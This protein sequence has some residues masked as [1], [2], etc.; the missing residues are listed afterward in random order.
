MD[1]EKLKQKILDLAIRGKLVPQDSN[2]ESAEELIKKIQEE[3]AKLVKEG[4]IKAS[5][6]ESIIFKGSDNCYYE[7]IGNEIKNISDEI[8][9]EIPENWSWIRLNELGLYRKGPFGSSLTKSMFVSEQTIGRIKV[10]EQRN[11]IQKNAHIG[12]YF[13]SKEKFD[14][15]QGFIVEPGDIIVSCAGT[16]GEIYILP[17]NSEIGIIN[18]AL[19]RIRLYYKGIEEYFVLY[20]DSILKKEANEKGMGSTIK[21]IPP[22]DIL[23]KMLLPLPPLNE[24]QRILEKISFIINEINEINTNYDDI[25]KL[26]I[27]IKSKILDNFFGEDSSY[28]SYYKP[29]ISTNLSEL[30]PNDNIGDGDWVLTENMDEN[31]NYSLIQLKHVGYGQYIEKPY[32]HVNQSFFETNNCKEIKEDYILI[33]RLIAD[34]MNVCILPQKGFKCIIAVDICWIAPSQTYN[35]KYIMYYLM[36]PTFQ[37]K[38][39]MITSGTTR[40]RISKTNLIKIPML[41]HEHNYQSK[42]VEEIENAFKILDSI[43]S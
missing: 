34:K 23:K 20:F 2:N 11:A 8:P 32:K 14:T 9:F 10:Y 5:K 30:I 7:K 3:K 27:K 12:N 21:N 39:K 40:K 22:F 43:V 15:M 16:I 4:K 6:E 24:I 36:S 31:G 19:M 35:Q 25:S 28:K 18:Q 1:T 38:V 41:I 26:V 37:N 13:I 17:D 29:T 42:I 33:N